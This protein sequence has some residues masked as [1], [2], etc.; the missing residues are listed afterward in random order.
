MIGEKD[1]EKTARKQ[2]EQ[3]YG[4]I[5]PSKQ[6]LYCVSNL[7]VMTLPSQGFTFGLER[8]ICHICWLG[9]SFANLELRFLPSSSVGA[10][11]GWIPIM[12][13]TCLEVFF[14][15]LFFL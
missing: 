3:W 10:L 12:N 15:F 2:M 4:A 14:L 5:A 9:T 7:I 11:S 13:S 8:C 1:D 6:W